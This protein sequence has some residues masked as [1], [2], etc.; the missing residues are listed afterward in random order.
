MPAD[1]AAAACY[2]EYARESETLRKARREY[3][4]TLQAERRP[5]RRKRRLTVTDAEQASHS[6]LSKFSGW[7]AGPAAVAVWQCPDY[8]RKPWR[9]L[10]DTRRK[11]LVLDL[12]AI[13][14]GS[15][16]TDVRMLAGMKIFEKFEQAARAA[17]KHN[18][19]MGFPARVK[20]PGTDYGVFSDGYEDVRVVLPIQNDAVQYVVFTLNYRDGVD[21]VKE[22]ISRWL[23]SEENQ[24]LFKRY[25]KLPFDKQSPDSP[26]RCKELLKY[27]AAWRLYDELGF[28]G[29]KKWTATNRRRLPGIPN[30][31]PFFNEKRK[32]TGEGQKHFV[33]PLFKDRREW[34]AARRIAR[35]FFETEFFESLK[36]SAGR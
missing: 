17:S 2:Y 13:G 33:G 29:A 31:A 34:K 27:L 32:K 8:P 14:P 30:P 22:G 18:E 21:A 10:T 36:E 11:K 6:V 12:G 28:K 35:L 9:G 1:E 20:L 7:I 25:H 24:K 4:R 19:R 3:G 23:D 26:V 15:V 5:R 16:I